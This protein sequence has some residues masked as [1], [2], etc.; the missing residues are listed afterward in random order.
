MVIFIQSDLIAL[1]RELIMTPP[2][3]VI[4]PTDDTDD[5][6]RLD[7]GVCFAIAQLLNHADLVAKC[8]IFHVSNDRDFLRLI[9]SRH[10]LKPLSG[11]A[12]LEVPTLIEQSFSMLSACL[13]LCYALSAVRAYR[14]SKNRSSKDIDG[15]MD[16]LLRIL[17]SHSNP[18]MKFDADSLR[19]VICRTRYEAAEKRVGQAEAKMYVYDAINGVEEDYFLGDE[20]R[21]D[22]RLVETMY[23]VS[24]VVPAK[25]PSK[26][27]LPVPMPSLFS[28]VR[29]RRSSVEGETPDTE[30]KC[31]ATSFGL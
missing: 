19:E 12:R 4:N 15:S 22:F 1:C 8:N 7:D 21:V 27:C 16:N 6:K 14:L 11:Y 18:E 30:T 23:R 20:K 29:S 25:D 31:L 13:H 9:A 10:P 5:G 24:C 2:A 28:P 17:G 26:V 3:L